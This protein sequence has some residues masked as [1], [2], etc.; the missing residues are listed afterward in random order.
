[1]STVVQQLASIGAD[2]QHEIGE[3]AAA[4]QDLVG[5]PLFDQASWNETRDGA[6]KVLHEEVP[7]YRS[8]QLDI[9]KKVG[10]AND[11]QVT[12]VTEAADHVRAQLDMIVQQVEHAL[13]AEA[14]Q[15]V[16]SFGAVVEGLGRAQLELERA[17][18]QGESTQAAAHKMVDLAAQVIDG[19]ATLREVHALMEE[20]KEP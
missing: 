10:S 14:Q 17:A 20:M 15:V 6:E 7:A 2:V 12:A 19:N 4:T 5:M 9:V 1:M 8:S 13:D 3:I 16:Q 18:V 11:Q